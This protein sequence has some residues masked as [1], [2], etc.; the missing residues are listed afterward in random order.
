MQQRTILNS[1]FLLACI[2]LI[3]TAYLVWK[4]YT[5]DPL[6]CSLIEGCNIV[7]ASSYSKILG[8]PLSLIGL[9]YYIVITV[10]SLCSHFI[11]TDLLR[12]SMLAVAL[13]GFISSAYFMYL[14]VFVIN[15]LCQYCII[16]AGIS[17]L[18]LIAT[19]FLKKSS[20]TE[21]PLPTA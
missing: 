16:S 9:G 8:I 21:S 3:D 13:L 1:I 20:A 6:S 5:G 7:A 10:L 14:Q 12:R 11:R 15:A 17:V 19:F 2:G 18:L 4:Y